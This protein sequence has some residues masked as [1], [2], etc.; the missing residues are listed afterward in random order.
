MKKIKNLLLLV[1]VIIAVVCCKADE[2][3]NYTRF[4]GE[5]TNYKGHFI[6]LEQAEVFPPRNKKIKIAD[7]GTFSDT[8]HIKD[9]ARFLIS[10]GNET[11]HLLLKKANDLNLTLDIND[12]YKTL[13]FEGRNARTNDYL[14][15]RIFINKKYYQPLFELDKQA[16]NDG[17]KKVLKNYLNLIEE[18]KDLDKD[19]YLKEKKFYSLKFEKHAKGSYEYSKVIQEQYAPSM[20]EEKNQYASFIG[21]PSPEFINYENFKGGT[22]SLKDFKGKYVYIDVWSTG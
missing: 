1:F 14:N 17:I 16:F 4:S 7:D 20:E 18:Y 19:L 15:K 10:I 12:P 21:K 8:L 13:T 5:I 9:K 3:K 11:F 22:S 6:K 2:P